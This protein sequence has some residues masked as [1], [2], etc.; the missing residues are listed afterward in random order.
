MHRS[1]LLLP[2][3]FVTACSGTDTTYIERFVP[4]DGPSLRAAGEASGDNL[5]ADG[6]VDNNLISPVFIQNT[7]SNAVDTVVNICAIEDACET[8]FFTQHSA[9]VTLRNDAVRGSASSEANVPGLETVTGYTVTYA[10]ADPNIPE[11]SAFALA[12]FQGRVRAVVA[13]GETTTVQVTLVPFERKA[14]IETLLGNGAPITY[15]AQIRMTGD[16]NLE[17][18]ASTTLVVGA[19]NNCPDGSLALSQ[20]ESLV[21][22][23]DDDT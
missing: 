16:N 20:T 18:L 21:F 4:F 7:Q 22:C 6:I 14:Q 10:F 1:A 11:T 12:P 9:W 15:I 8:E 2:F 19:F 17:L 23:S 3:L 13:P 5:S